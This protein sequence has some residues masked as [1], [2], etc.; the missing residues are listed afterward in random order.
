MG[1]QPR[2]ATS[3]TSMIMR[4]IHPVHMSKRLILKDGNT[5]Q[6]KLT[7]KGELTDMESGGTQTE[8][9]ISASLRMETGL[10][11][12][13]TSYNQMALTLYSK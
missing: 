4:N 11:V 5:T 6:L 9:F 8:P 7:R 10:R 1:D 13:S 2:T 3:L 12:K